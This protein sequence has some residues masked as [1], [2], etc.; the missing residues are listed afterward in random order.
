[1]RR[2]I[3][4]LLII[5]ALVI[6]TIIKK[7]T[8]SYTGISVLFFIISFYGFKFLFSKDN[9]SSNEDD[10][11]INSNNLNSK[12]EKRESNFHHIKESQQKKSEIKG[13]TIK[14]DSE[15][16]EIEKIEKQYIKGVFTASERDE[17]ISNINLKKQTN[18]LKDIEDKYLDKLI[19]EYSYDCKELNELHLNGHFDKLMLKDKLKYLKDR[20]ETNKAKI[21]TKA[22]LEYTKILSK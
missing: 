2:G 4:C 10:I 20:L 18:Y 5:I 12:N 14:I 21:K 13:S 19:H 7:N 9:S 8:G 3:G 15:I 16:S 1:M 6:L 17:L 22:L 11:N